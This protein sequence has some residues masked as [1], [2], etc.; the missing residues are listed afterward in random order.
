MTSSLIK[1]V[2]LFRHVTEE[3]FFSTLT[4]QLAPV[5]FMRHETLILEQSHNDEMFFLVRGDAM[6]LRGLPT[7]HLHRRLGPGDYCGENMLLRQQSISSVVAHTP[8]ECFVLKAHKLREVL[9]YFPNADEALAAQV[10]Q[11][12]QDKKDEELKKA[13]KALA[14]AAAAGRGAPAAATDLS[15]IHISEPTR[16]Y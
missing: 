2:P 15:L 5:V 3:G 7:P 9:A 13:Q 10:Q 14:V 1:G 4:T 6:E 11:A 8:C 16:P 12:Q